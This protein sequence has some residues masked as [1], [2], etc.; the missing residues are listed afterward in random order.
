MILNGGTS[1]HCL[2]FFRRQYDVQDILQLP[3]IQDYFCH[4]LFLSF[5]PANY[6]MPDIFLCFC[7]RI[8]NNFST[9]DWSEI[10]RS[11]NKTR[12]NI[13]LYTISVHL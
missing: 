7:S 2:R 3:C 9:D 4:V 1:S 8:L 6:Y 10:L 11:E 12:E 13:F 5:T